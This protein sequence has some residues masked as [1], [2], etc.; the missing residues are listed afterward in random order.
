MKLWKGCS[1]K[2][3]ETKP[4]GLLETPEN[5]I[6]MGKARLINRVYRNFP[7]HQAYNPASN[8]DT[9]E[10]HALATVGIGI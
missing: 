7:V 9:V 6:E 2:R 1:L 3:F 10:L 5:P 8:T 4:S